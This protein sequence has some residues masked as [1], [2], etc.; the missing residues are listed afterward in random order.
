[1]SPE[2]Q[3]LLGLVAAQLTAAWLEAY[4]GP[5]CPDT[6]PTCVVCQRWRAFDALF[7][8]APQTNPPAGADA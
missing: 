7:A 2:H 1:M 8:D 5:R 3:D 6:E 4:A